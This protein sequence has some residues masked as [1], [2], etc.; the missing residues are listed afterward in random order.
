MHSL[1]I[2]SVL[3]LSL[4]ITG[5]SKDESNAI[6]DPS[7]VNNAVTNGTW[8]ITY[9]WDTDKDET[10]HFS[11]YQFTFGT[12]GVLTASNG[13]TVITGAWS[14]GTD[15]SGLKMVIAF[16]SPA[17]FEELSEDWHIL[18]VTET[19]MQLQHVSGGGG[20]TDYLTFERN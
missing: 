2:L 5:C 10:A 20:G 4:W 18:E 17:D 16:S 8:R 14:S 12:G 3:A 6:S 15:D 13:S 7:G 1:K 11:G 19:K 9:F